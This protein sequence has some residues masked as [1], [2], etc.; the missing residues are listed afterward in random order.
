VNIMASKISEPAPS[1]PTAVV[2]RPRYGAAADLPDSGWDELLIAISDGECT[3][4]LGPGAS[5]GTLP[6]GSELARQWAEQYDYPLADSGNLARVAEFLALERYE[7]FPKELLVR[8]FRGVEPPDFIEPDEPHSALADLPLPVYLTTNY[9]A[10]MMQALRFRNRVPRSDLLRWNSYLEYRSVF[11]EEP[12]F[13]PTAQ[14]PIVFHLAGSDTLPES[15]VLTESDCL[16][17]QVNVSRDPEMLPVRIQQALAAPCLLFIGCNV[18]D[19][20]YRVLFQSPAQ[21][22]AL[23]LRKVSVAIQLP[24]RDGYDSTQ[25]KTQDYLKKILGKM[26]THV[27]W[28]TAREFA[29]ELRERWEAFSNE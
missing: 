27:Y 21:S 28:G 16:E 25:E 18:T 20:S 6:L 15:L 12:D 5:A 29:A 4:I 1:R 9:D 13:E 19:W 10:F 24:P 7:M 26:V 3:P 23:N 11:D 2:E 17:F 14:S 8:Q 22:R